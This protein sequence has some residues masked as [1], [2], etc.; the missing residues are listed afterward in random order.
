MVGECEDWGLFVGWVRMGGLLEF[1]F[2]VG[3]VE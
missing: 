1:V 3:V 2:D